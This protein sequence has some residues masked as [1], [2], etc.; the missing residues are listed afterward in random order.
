MPFSA[1]S[2]LEEARS[3]LKENSSEDAIA[4]KIELDSTRQELSSALANVEAL[5]T[6]KLESDDA[7]SR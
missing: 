2:Q 7:L 6:D 5:K 3:H 1:E 4:Y